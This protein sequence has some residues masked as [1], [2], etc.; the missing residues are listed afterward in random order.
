ML[1][2]QVEGHEVRALVLLICI[3]TYMYI[4][5]HI[6]GNLESLKYLNGK[7]IIKFAFIKYHSDHNVNRIRGK[8][9]RSRAST[10]SLLWESGWE[11]KAASPPAEPLSAE[12]GAESRGVEEG[13]S[14]SAM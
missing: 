10:S 14:D 3:V 11:V 5:V 7:S 8:E 1:D 9:D 2:K 4:C 6:C 13:E 12:K